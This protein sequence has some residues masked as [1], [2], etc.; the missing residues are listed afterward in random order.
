[1]PFSPEVANC[2]F[3]RE[4][5]KF[6]KVLGGGKVLCRACE[7]CMFFENRLTL[8]ADFAGQPFK[9]MGWTRQVLRDLFGTLDDDGYRVYKD[10]Y[11][12]I[13][14]KNAKTAL[15]AGLALFC[16]SSARGTGTEVYSAATTKD[17]AS[18]L[19]RAASQMVNANKTLREKFRMVPSTKRIL[20]ADDP[21][22][23]YAALSADGDVHDG[24]QPSF[25][26]R[27]ELHRWRTRKALELNE[28][29]ERGMITRKEGLVIDITTA[30]VADESPLCWRRHEYTR[31]INEGV[32]TDRR[33]YGRVWSADPD[34]LHADPDYWATR[35]ARVAANPSHEDNGGYLKDATLADLCVKAQNDPIARSDYKRYHL[36]VWDQKVTRWMPMDVWRACG[37]ETR[38]LIERPCYA[39]LDLSST[40]D[41]TSLVLLFHDEK[42]DSYDVLPF[43]WM[44]S[45]NVRKRELSDHVPY[46]KW[47]LDGQ[48]ETTEGNVIDYEA[49]KAKVIWASELF[50]LR[51]LAY[52]PRSATQIAIQLGERGITCVPIQQSFASLSEPMKKL[53]DLALSQKLRHGGHPV[54]TW[55][56]DCVEAKSDGYDNIRPVK[57]ERKTSNKRID[58]ILALIMALD[59][60]MRNESGVIEYAGLRSVG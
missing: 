40:I 22:S 38:R 11:L 47:V 24:V 28:V 33:F 54:L 10:A 58:G 17:Q 6:G 14:K 20:R 19:F 23:F 27:D 13:P 7:V 36:N 59:R 4:P 49:I 32:F 9:L 51:E 25:I 60:D 56:A 15:C 1:M 50:E 37:A 41:L 46:S 48:I 8:T 29:L 31:Q 55:N 45:D 39:G 18:Q 26:V 16:L 3:C 42:D 30:G 12:E 44:P 52:D 43:F 5:I 2:S 53:M 35:E 34:K 21:S 57:P